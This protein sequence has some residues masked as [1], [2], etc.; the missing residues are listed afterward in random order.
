MRFLTGG[1]IILFSIKGM[2][3]DGMMYHIGALQ[4]QIPLKQLLADQ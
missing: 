4:L 2:S 1:Q 3:L